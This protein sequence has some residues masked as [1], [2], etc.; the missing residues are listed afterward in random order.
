MINRVLLLIFVALFTTNFSFSQT[1]GTYVGYLS[2]QAEK[3]PDYY[4]KLAEKNKHFET[5]HKAALKTMVNSKGT[6][7]KKR[8]IPVVVH[9]VY[10][11]AG[12]YISDS[13]IQGA[14]DAL[15]RNVNGQSD[16]LLELYQNQ[17]SKTPDI[18]ASVRG[19]A[20]IEFRLAK[21]TPS[22]DPSLCDT[23]PE[24]QPT[25]GINRIFTDITSGGS[26]GGPDPV[27]TLGYWNSYQYFNIWTVRSF[28]QSGLLGYAQ[29]PIDPN[30]GFGFGSNF[31][32]TDGVVL[33]S[34]EMR[35]DQSSTLT[36]E[37]GHW[38]GLRHIWGDAPCGDD[39]IRDTPFHRYDNNGA[40]ESS[41]TPAGH[42]RPTPAIFPYHVG[43]PAPTG[44][45]GAWGCTADSL[46]PAGEMFMN[47]M[48]YTSDQFTT[49]FSAG[50]IEKVNETLDGV[51]NE[52]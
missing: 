4:K 50:Q 18:F 6:V 32:S 46:N 1:C 25:T 20:N 29:F 37:A 11:A 47:Y 35:D 42:P 7:G 38:L 2:D 21:W 19:V 41:P 30:S 16:Q 27:K 43:I 31:M 10:S 39:G 51:I 23:C 3:Y 52:E 24:S 36:H 22:V 48:D 44:Q 40:S 5:Q 33:L 9:N 28:S 14:I 49:M 34:S 8:I 15:N 12:G 13:E 26:D 17:Y 45:S